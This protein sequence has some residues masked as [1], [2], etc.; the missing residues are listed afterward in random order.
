MKTKILPMALVVC[1][2]TAFTGC[3]HH[4]EDNISAATNSA[5]AARRIAD[6][7]RGRFERRPDAAGYHDDYH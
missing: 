3:G 2:V 1:A 7:R 5:A 4:A 6:A